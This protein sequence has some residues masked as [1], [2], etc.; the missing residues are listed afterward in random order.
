MRLPILQRSFTKFYSMMHLPDLTGMSCL[1]YM[2]QAVFAGATRNKTLPDFISCFA[3]HVGECE[4]TGRNGSTANYRMAYR[5][6]VRY[7][8]GGKLPPE[9]FTAEWL[10]HYERWLLARGLGTNSVVFHMRSLR[11]VYNRAVEQ[12]LFPAAGSNP[13]RRRLIK[14]VATRKRALPRETLRRIGGAD[15]SALH[16]KYALARDLFM[17]SFYTRGM[18]F[19]DMIYLR[20]SDVRDGVLTYRRKKTGQTLSLRVEAPLQKIIDRYD[21]DSPYVLPVL[22]ADDSYRAYRQQQRELN[23]FI[24]KIGEL[25][26]ISEPLTFYV[27]KHHTISI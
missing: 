24:R 25:L 16:P 8:G 11:A 14:Q 27:A 23:K 4:R 26:G 1:A 22:T 3:R 2:G 17:F 10:E 13:F 18:S 19:V 5:M 20:K 21:S 6:L 12:G 7:V 15:L 9:Q